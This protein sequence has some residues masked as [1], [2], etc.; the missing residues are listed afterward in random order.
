MYL[1]NVKG[2]LS[3]HEIH[4]YLDALEM[5]PVAHGALRSVCVF[6]LIM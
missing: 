3:H 5:E 6:F 2:T 1:E 4:S